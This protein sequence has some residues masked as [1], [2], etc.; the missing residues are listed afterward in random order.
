MEVACV[1]VRAQVLKA[2][3]SEIVYAGVHM[4]VLVFEG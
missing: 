1:S 3:L 2:K 4:Y